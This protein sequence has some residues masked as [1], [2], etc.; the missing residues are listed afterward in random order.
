MQVSL[1]QPCVRRRSTPP[2]PNTHTAARHNHPRAKPL[3]Q[4]TTGRTWGAQAASTR[5]ELPHP[6]SLS[7]GQWRAMLPLC[8][9]R[10]RPAKQ[11]WHA[12]ASHLP[13]AIAP[14]GTP[15]P[16]DAGDYPL[17]DLLRKSPK[18]R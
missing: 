4:D 1:H 18:T 13:G 2:L 11:T 9:E 5:R 8:Y 12:R 10:G 3:N 17:L 16:T 6:R 14:P 15:S 7:P